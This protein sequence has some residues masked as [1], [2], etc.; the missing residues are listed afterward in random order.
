MSQPVDRL[1]LLI[2]GAG[3]TG[4]AIG[5]EA[6]A[7]GISAL[8]V[9]RGA[10]TQAILDFPT[11]MTFFTT[12]DLLEIAGV[13]FAVPEDKP[14]R[15]QALSYYRAVARRFALDVAMHEEVIA[16]EGDRAGFRV[17][18]RGRRG[19]T[20]R[21]AGAVCFATGYFGNPRRLGVAGEDLA[22]VEA[23]Y[24]DPWRHTGERVVVVGG[25][26]SA[27][28]AALELWRAGAEVTMVVRGAGFKPTL[29]YWVR[30]D[31]ENR[32]AEGS[33][34][35]LFETEV[36]RFEDGRVVAGG[37]SLPADHA[38]VLIGYEPEMGLL[39]RAGIAIDPLTLVPAVD[40]ETCESSIP[41]LFVAGTLQAGR[42][43]GK[44][45]IENSRDH[46]ARIVRR[47]V[48]CFGSRR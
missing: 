23:R 6:S 35:A 20:E 2:V 45:F 36:T 38:F 1:D 17:L 3:P 47:Y 4:I 24:R 7:A 37:Q 34:R 25:G 8:L 18:G 16:V 15:R 19:A 21:R 31:L 9:E 5:A 10:L 22:W 13:P 26:N 41:G 12:R 28:E 44:I 29:K 42:D 43:T 30:P 40:P 33:I 46:G 14:D 11:Y 48:S 39:E 32:V 27:A